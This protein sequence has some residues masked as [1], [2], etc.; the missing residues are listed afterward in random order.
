MRE[1]EEE[2][3]RC[4]LKIERMRGFLSY[5]RYYVEL[6]EVYYGEGIT[7]CFLLLPLFFHFGVNLHKIQVKT[8]YFSPVGVSDGKRENKCFALF[9]KI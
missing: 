2:R 9:C 7:E 6:R 4:K 1:K 5:V 3:E 8:F